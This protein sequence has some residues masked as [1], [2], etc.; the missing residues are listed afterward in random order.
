MRVMFDVTDPDE[1]KHT[2]TK[3]KGK[4]CPRSV[5]VRSVDI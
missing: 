5:V 2:M 3:W 1:R 4:A